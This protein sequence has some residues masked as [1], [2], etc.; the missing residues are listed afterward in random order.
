[1]AGDTPVGVISAYKERSK[2]ENQKA[3]GQLMAELQRMGYSPGQ[4]RPLRG[5]YFTAEGGEMKAEQ[6]IMVLGADFNDLVELGQ[7]LEQ[8]SIIYKTPEGVVG[9]YYT[10][11]SGRVNYALTETGDLAVG[12]QAADVAVREPKPEKR[13]PP[14]PEDPWSKAR[15]TAF[16]FGIDWDKTYQ[17]DPAA[18]PAPLEETQQQVLAPAPERE[19]AAQVSVVS[20][21]DLVAAAP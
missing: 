15:S 17:Y 8:E 21:H 2:K 13:G 18:G 14:S 1:M 10:D 5:Q 19:V 6:S 7:M 9:A 11:G 12:E 20:V 3:H 16:E 4:I